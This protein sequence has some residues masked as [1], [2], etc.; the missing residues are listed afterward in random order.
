MI[1]ILSDWGSINGLPLNIKKCSILKNNINLNYHINS[2]TLAK[3]E[4]I[5]DL[6]VIFNNKLNFKEHIDYVFA[7]SMRS[8][9]FLKRNCVEFKNI[10]FLISNT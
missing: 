10:S 8:L 4:S 3:V 9:G 7:K 6:G 2:Y 5:K 1:L